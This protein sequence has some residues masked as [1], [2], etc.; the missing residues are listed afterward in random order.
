[1]SPSIPALPDGGTC[2]LTDAGFDISGA[3]SVTLLLSAS[4][5]YV[6]WDDLTADQVARSPTPLSAAAMQSYAALRAA[7]IADFSPKMGRGGF[8]VG[9]RWKGGFLESA[10]VLSVQ[11]LPCRIRSDR[12]IVVHNGR[13]RIS[14]TQGAPDVYAFPTAS[15]R[16]YT[17]TTEGKE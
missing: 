9:M 3:N 10:S 15:G 14:V 17:I 1:V 16:F 8:T 11:G 4:T 6:T 7:H 5:N 13:S 2:H 12:P